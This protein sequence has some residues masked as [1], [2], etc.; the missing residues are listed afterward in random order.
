MQEY[1]VLFDGLILENERVRLSALK[2]ED[3]DSLDGIA[4][5]PRLWEWGMSDIKTRQDLQNYISTALK[6][7]DLFQSYPFL[8]YDKQ[9]NKVAGSTRFGSISIPNKRLEIGWTWLHPDFHGSGLNKNCKYLLLKCAF[10]EFKFNRVEIKT[11][12]LNKQSRAAILKIGAKEEGIFR[13]HQ[14][15][16]SGRERDSIYFSIIKD[17]W[18]QLKSRVFASLNQ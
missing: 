1:N 7:R 5:D 8:I 12:V 3:I 11:D 15:T 4:Y 13:K 16:A 2:A 10:E 18:P 14:I 17:E 6:E 9:N